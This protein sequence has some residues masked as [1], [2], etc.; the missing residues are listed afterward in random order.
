M[1]AQHSVTIGAP[2]AQV[3]EVYADVERWPEWTASVSSVTLLDA[4][5]LRLGTRA[6]IKQPRFPP[7]VW[8]VATIEPDRTW[9]WVTRSPGSVATG[10][11]T[12]VPVGPMTTRV[13]LSIDQTGPLG[14]LV[15]R[16]SRRLTRRYLA[17][18]AAGL[19]RRVEGD[20]PAG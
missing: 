13:E 10:T 7:L 1:N 6:R 20:G 2:A 19:K 3:W 15:G 14:G 11:H 5:P 16:L 9:S 12:V 17:M 18:E 8:T 4:G